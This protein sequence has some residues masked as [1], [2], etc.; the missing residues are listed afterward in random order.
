MRAIIDIGVKLNLIHLREVERLKI[1]YRKKEEPIILRTFN[2][3]NPA[4]KEGKAHLETQKQIVRIKDR[5]FNIKFTITKLS[6][7]GIILRI[8]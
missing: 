1:P 2:R 5:L 7:E 4:Y 3:T 6:K 8:P